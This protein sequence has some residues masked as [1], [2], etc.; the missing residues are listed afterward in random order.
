MVGSLLDMPH[1]PSP[2][3]IIN[4]LNESL[5]RTLSPEMLQTSDSVNASIFLSYQY[6]DRATQKSGRYLSLFPGLF[7]QDTACAMIKK[8]H[9]VGS[10]PCE[11][12]GIL[13][14]RSL[15]KSLSSNALDNVELEVYLYHRL[16]REFFK[17]MSE[18]KELESF[19]MNFIRH[20]TLE[21]KRLSQS[22]T[23][24]LNSL[25]ETIINWQDIRHFYHLLSSNVTFPRV[26]QKEANIIVKAAE[27]IGDINMLEFGFYPHETQKYLKDML[28]Y[29]NIIMRD[30]AK[31]FTRKKIFEVYAKIVLQLARAEKVFTR[32]KS[33][34]IRS[35]NAYRW[36]FL[37]YGQLVPSQEY[38]SYFSTLANNYIEI[39]NYD[40]AIWC[41]ERILLKE[42][43]CGGN[44]STLQ[45][46][47]VFER[48]RDEKTSR[49][50]LNRELKVRF[51]VPLTQD[52]QKTLETMDILCQLYSIYSAYNNLH[53]MKQVVRRLAEITNSIVL[54]PLETI[55]NIQLAINAAA[56]LQSMNATSEMSKLKDCL[57]KGIHETDEVLYIIQKMNPLTCRCA[58]PPTSHL[59][60]VYFT[61][62]AVFVTENV[63][64]LLEQK[65]NISMA[66]RSHKLRPQMLKFTGD[67]LYWL[68]N[69]TGS[70]L[71]YR[72]L[73]QYPQYRLPRVCFRLVSMG[74]FECLP[75]LVSLMISNSFTAFHSLYDSK[76]LYTVS[77]SSSTQQIMD[78]DYLSNDMTSKYETGVAIF[79]DSPLVNFEE[80]PQLKFSKM[81]FS[82]L[83]HFLQLV[84][85]TCFP[86]CAI[87]CCCCPCYTWGTCRN[88]PVTIPLCRLKCFVNLER[89]YRVTLFIV[90]A[91]SYIITVA[92]TNLL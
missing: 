15:L 27:T 90:V 56:I 39:N 2:Q 6:L 48:K 85:F 92:N 71:Y 13:V 45:L 75:Q 21:L 47:E 26:Q 19:N 74:S 46:A 32:D 35:M 43:K 3:K 70:A 68:Q 14:K 66:L 91:Y 73:V 80:T 17:E 30:L 62:I 81:S 59:V 38:I 12:P 86:C 28:S 72:K 4:Q 69:Y 58:P 41:H 52:T 65:H 54:T 18:S 33:T 5:I 82:L 22:N 63:L 23:E 61:E 25:Y 16:I 67:L 7:S 1:P 89:L 55:E 76:T 42:N 29:L 34:L 60:Q 84:F 87:G 11:T 40:K 83:F 53:N 9:S 50:Y 49:I 44:C 57:K 37:K 31:Y 78:N 36:A 77:S 24:E 10:T 51:Q 79:E 20:Y 88:Y 8:I 64:E